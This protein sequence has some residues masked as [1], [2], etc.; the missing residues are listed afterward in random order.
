MAYADALKCP[1]SLSNFTLDRW[2]EKCGTWGSRGILEQGGVL[3][4]L[5]DYGEEESRL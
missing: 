2:W 5:G 3:I 4:I 1:Y